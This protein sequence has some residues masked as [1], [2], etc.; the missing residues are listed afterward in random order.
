MNAEDLTALIASGEGLAVEF[1]SE[2]R[3]SLPGRELDICKRKRC[4]R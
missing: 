1:K 4:D 2:R 3:E